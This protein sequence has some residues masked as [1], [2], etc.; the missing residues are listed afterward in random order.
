[1]R[2]NSRT[3]IPRSINIIFAS[4]VLI[5][6]V[7]I[8]LVYNG[9]LFTS[10]NNQNVAYYLFVSLLLFP[11]IYFLY[12]I[13]L[14]IFKI[15]EGLAGVVALG[16]SLFGVVLFVLGFNTAGSISPVYISIC[17]P[18]Y[19]VG[20]VI[21]QSMNEDSISINV[22]ETVISFVLSSYVSALVYILSLLS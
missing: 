19:L 18:V 4:I 1:V 20:S 3:K 17:G 5:S 8:F 6:F 7:S 22:L 9:Y 2:L 10:T 13:G 16:I 15:N 12:L 11:A 14:K 21:L